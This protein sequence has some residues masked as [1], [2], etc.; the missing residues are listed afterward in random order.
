MD[1][2][3]DQTLSK[4][5]WAGLSGGPV[6]KTSPS[7]AGVLIWSLVKELRYHM[8][9]SKKNHKTENRNNIVTNSILLF[10]CEALLD[11]ATT[12]TA[13]CQASLSF[14]ISWSLLK[15]MSIESMMPSN[16]LILCCPLHLLPS[17][18]PSIRVFFNES[19]LPIR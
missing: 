10:S 8:P 5:K 3:F 18:F 17:I 19:I 14:S 7:S 4:R 15:L 16:N 13:A 2:I 6:V 1:K 9:T 11:S 12:W